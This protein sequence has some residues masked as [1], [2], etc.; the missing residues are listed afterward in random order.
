MY[1]TTFEISGIGPVMHAMRNPMDNW[2]KGDTVG[3]MDSPCVGEKDKELSIRLQKAG[4]EHCKHLRMI[5]VWTE[6]CGAQSR[7]RHGKN[8]KTGCWRR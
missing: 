1:I 6:I 7:K 2:D 4:P 3:A 5:M 8:T